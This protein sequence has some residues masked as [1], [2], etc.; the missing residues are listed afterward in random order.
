MSL[1][2][3]ELSVVLDLKHSHKNERMN[4]NEINEGYFV[5][6]KETME[7]MHAYINTLSRGNSGIYHE[8][9]DTSPMDEVSTV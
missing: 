1:R 4:A 2:H 3:E 5:K 6:I 8:S 7:E 9:N